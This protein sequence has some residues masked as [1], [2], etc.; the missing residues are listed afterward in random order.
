VSEHFQ[1]SDT[2]KQLAGRHAPGAG[3]IALGRRPSQHAVVVGRWAL[4]CAVLA[5]LA[6]APGPPPA[7]AQGSGNT[8][9][10][11]PLFDRQ[12]QREPATVEDRPEAPIA[13]VAGRGS[14]QAARG[15]VATL[16][17]DD[18]ERMARYLATLGVPP[19]RGLD[20]PQARRGESLFLQA[21]C[22]GCHRPASRTSD[23]HP[24][25]ELRSQA[26]RPYTDLRLHDTG[27]GLADNMAEGTPARRSG[28]ARRCG[29]LG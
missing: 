1:L 17:G 10:L 2:G 11:V 6:A 5:L 9:W 24:L 13:R 29:A 3:P 18:L 12:T 27:P 25:A 20:D 16:P 21:R 8:T 28:A 14:A 22:D 7:V 15:P 23:F 19:R 26:I 4:A